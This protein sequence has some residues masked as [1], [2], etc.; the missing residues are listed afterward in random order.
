MNDSH[1]FSKKDRSPRIMLAT[2][3]NVTASTAA[4]RDRV[5]I[6]SFYVFH[7]I[8][9]CGGLITFLV[10]CVSGRSSL[11]TVWTSFRGFSG[12]HS[13]SSSSELLNNLY[14]LR[15][16]SALGRMGSAL[17]DICKTTYIPPTLSYLGSRK[18][19]TALSFTYIVPTSLPYPP[20]SLGTCP[21][22]QLP[23]PDYI[24]T[25]RP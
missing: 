14:E 5:T 13:V 21:T 17:F 25:S 11:R 22:L 1:G 7:S 9:R 2:L 10:I 3:F 18:V 19:G 24:G 23:L 8:R 6:T 15:F 20:L 16:R 4:C 12:V